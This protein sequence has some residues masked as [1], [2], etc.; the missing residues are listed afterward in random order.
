MGRFDLIAAQGADGQL[1]AL[2]H[3]SF[4]ADHL[5]L[6]AGQIGQ[7]T[8]EIRIAPIF[9]MELLGDAVQRALQP[10]QFQRLVLGA[11]G[12]VQG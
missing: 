12:D 3:L 11:K 1:M 6:A 9:P 4:L 5:A 8:G 7:K 10:R 2:R